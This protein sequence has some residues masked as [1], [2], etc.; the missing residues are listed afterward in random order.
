MGPHIWPYRSLRLDASLLCGGRMD[1]AP[2]PPLVRLTAKPGFSNVGNP[3][4]GLPPRP[5]RA[6]GF[7]WRSRRAGARSPG[8]SRGEA[9]APAPVGV[10][11][12]QGVSRRRSASPTTGRRAPGG[13]LSPLRGPRYSRREDV[14]RGT[15]ALS[16]EDVPHELSGVES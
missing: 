3:A 9:V 2:A 12:G 1:A 10:P 4:Q 16:Y 11:E 13:L 6:R 7:G 5:E 15:R 8:N 14:R